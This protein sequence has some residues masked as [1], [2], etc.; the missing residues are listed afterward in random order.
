MKILE[1][2]PTQIRY[3]KKNNP[4]VYILGKAVTNILK[5]S[6]LTLINYQ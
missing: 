5:D 1:T 2:K 3:E 4:K 6:H